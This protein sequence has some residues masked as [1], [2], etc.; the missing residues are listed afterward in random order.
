MQ[1]KGMGIYVI[2]PFFREPLKKRPFCHIWYTESKVPVV[3]RVTKF[4]RAGG[5]IGGFQSGKKKFLRPYLLG[6][7]TPNTH[8]H[9]TPISVSMVATKCSRGLV[10]SNNL[11]VNFDKQKNKN[12]TGIAICSKNFSQLEDVSKRF[13]EW[14]EL[15]RALGAEKIIISIL[16]VHQ[17][18]MKV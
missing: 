18:V 6:C 3:S 2:F 17:N 15:L 7:K 9:R 5:I 16:A 14:I 8:R 11:R 13:I 12:K 4:E 10:P 1:P